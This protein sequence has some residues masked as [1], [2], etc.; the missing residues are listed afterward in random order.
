MNR[1]NPSLV[2]SVAVSCLLV[3]CGNAKLTGTSAKKTERRVTSPATN[4][5]ATGQDA[6]AT[7]Q[8][9]P[10][11]TTGTD[12]SG[13]SQG[14]SQ[15]SVPPLSTPPTSAETKSDGEKAAQ[16]TDFKGWCSKAQETK[17]I[18]SGR[19]KSLLAEFCDGS[20]PREL[21]T[22]TLISSAYL[23]TGEPKLTDL[24]PL[25]SQGTTRTSSYLFAVAIKIPISI[26][27]HFEK[28]SPKAGDVAEIKKLQESTGAKATVTLQKTHTGDGPYQ[29]Q[30]WST[31]SVAVKTVFITSI[32]SQATSRN[33]T[34]KFVDG[35]QYLYSQSTY[36][37]DPVTNA[38]PKTVKYFDYLAAGVKIGDSHYLI[39]VVNVALDNYGF[40]TTA[41]T[42]IRK[43]AVFGIKQMHS[44]AAAAK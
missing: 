31:Q 32:E 44:L 21:L 11:G 24:K 38:P 30:G 25:V 9:T 33:D 16:L 2:V 39:T 14:P 37:N 34:F 15:P 35:E 23:G 40:A 26:K 29:V 13:A 20:Q 12:V 22:K 8:G 4:N 28:V 17:P 27:D 6:S 1:L 41:E 3:S 42:E 19:L 10:Q 5:T 7:P 43:L 36:A 18:T